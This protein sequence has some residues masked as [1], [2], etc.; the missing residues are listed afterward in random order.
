MT[1]SERQVVRFPGHEIDV[2]HFA[3]F[4]DVL[5]ARQV[6]QFRLGELEVQLGPAAPDTESPKGPDD[7]RA[8]VAA[9]DNALLFSAVAG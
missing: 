2:A 4:L 8:A 9:E 5:R 6:S 3:A 7:Q 1:I